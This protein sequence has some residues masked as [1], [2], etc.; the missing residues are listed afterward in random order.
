MFSTK[1]L[2][3]VLTKMIHPR[4]NNCNESANT[5]RPENL[6]VQGGAPLFRSRLYSALKR[7]TLGVL[8]M[9]TMGLGEAMWS[10][11]LHNRWGYFLGIAVI[12]QL[13]IIPPAMI[14]WGLIAPR[15]MNQRPS[16]G[17]VFAWIL[18]FLLG[19]F[20]SLEFTL[21]AASWAIWPPQSLG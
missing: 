18:L 5:C 15:T 2:W 16:F 9:G 14:T 17:L 8:Y 20:L 12:L 6:P 3:R 11:N 7:T 1:H 21:F 10:C 4:S 13:A 19:L